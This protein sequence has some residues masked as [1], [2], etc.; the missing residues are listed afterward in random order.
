MTLKKSAILGQLLYDSD[1]F[2]IVAR[3]LCD[4]VEMVFLQSKASLMRNPLR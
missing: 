4:D 2:G 1:R 3:A